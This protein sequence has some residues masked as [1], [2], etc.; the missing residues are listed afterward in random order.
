MCSENSL[1]L[2]R[3]LPLGLHVVAGRD[4]LFP[5]GSSEL[6]YKRPVT[7]MAVPSFP[8]LEE[9]VK[10]KEVSHRGK[11]AGNDEFPD[12]GQSLD[13]LCSCLS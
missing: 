9:G 8:P 6:K 12:M 5:Q 2:K 1:E 11:E 3:D 7:A 13:P 10:S 4:L